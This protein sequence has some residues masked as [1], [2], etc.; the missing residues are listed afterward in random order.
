MQAVET[1]LKQDFEDYYKRQVTPSLTISSK[2]N[3]LLYKS[4][5]LESGYRPIA[6]KSLKFNQNLIVILAVKQGGM[7]PSNFNIITSLATFG[8]DHDALESGGADEE[9]KIF[10]Y[11]EFGQ[12]VHEFNSYLMPT[13]SNTQSLKF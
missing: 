4:A 3:V 12:L 11:N 13:L 5:Q 7:K 2:K 10:V 6:M 9:S 1:R 8:A